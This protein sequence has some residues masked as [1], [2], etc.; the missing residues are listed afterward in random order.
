[1]LK[2]ESRC[3]ELAIPRGSNEIFVGGIGKSDISTGFGVKD[4]VTSLVF[5]L[6]SVGVLCEGPLST[7]GM[8]T[9]KRRMMAQLKWSNIKPEKSP[10][11]LSKELHFRIYSLIYKLKGFSKDRIEV[12]FCDLRIHTQRGTH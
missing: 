4:D 7:L 3:E 2:S 11:L 12:C 6:S 10:Y 8:D 5:G 1:M 9:R